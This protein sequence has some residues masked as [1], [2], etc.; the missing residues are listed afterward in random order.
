MT[1]V[2]RE[3]VS[4]VPEAGTVECRVLGGLAVSLGGRAVDLGGPKQRLLLAMLVCRANTVVGVSDLLDQLWQGGAPPSGRK[5]I[6]AYVCRLRKVLGD[7]LESVGRGYRLRLGSD[8]CDLLRFDRLVISGRTRAEAG[9]SAGAAEVL[10]S[11]IAGWRP[12]LAEFPEL[13]AEVAPWDELFLCVLEEWAE[14]MAERGEHQIVLDRLGVHVRAHPMRERLGAVWLRSLSAVGRRNEALAHFEMVRR[15]LVEEFGVEPGSAL[16]TAHRSVMAA[17]PRIPLG[18]L[19]PRDL[20][21]M[22][23][24]SHELSRIVDAFVP[25]RDN[26]AIVLTGPVGAGKSVL[27]VR[28]A[29]LLAD[30]FP[31]GQLVVDLRAPDGTALPPAAVLSEL[32]DLIGVDA[33]PSTRRALAAWRSWAVGRRVLVVLDNAVGEEIVRAVIPG[34]EGGTIVTSSH[35]LRGL[36]GVERIALPRLGPAEGIDLLGRIVGRSRVLAELPA[37]RGIVQIC[38]GSPLAIRSTGA[39]IDALPHIRL[40]DVLNRLVGASHLPDE[41]PGCSGRLRGAYNLLHGGLSDLQRAAYRRIAGDTGSYRHDQLLAELGDL[42]D[43]GIE[44]LVEANVLLP[45][46]P[47]DPGFDYVLPRLAAL[48]PPEGDRVG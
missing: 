12:L 20:P 17:V 26:A 8:N 3:L 18:T 31:D 46:G 27:A 11:A 33:I 16:T 29:R 5:N 39:R 36:D 21:D 9:N 2:G 40:I 1:A 32:L 19:L 7:R 44:A 25:R 35:R 10:G 13:A 30:T 38:E 41:V 43:A 4:H 42:G 6:Q 47:A 28:A 37:A 45:A 23:G 24:R 15:A 14:L 22:V 48:C 34:G